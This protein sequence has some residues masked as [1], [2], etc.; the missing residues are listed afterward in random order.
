MKS[1]TRY[2]L[3]CV[4]LSFCLTGTLVCIWNQ[5]L[6]SSLSDQTPIV[7]GQFSLVNAPANGVPFPVFQP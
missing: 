3:S 2:V 4:I 7:S 1:L 6:S 5:L